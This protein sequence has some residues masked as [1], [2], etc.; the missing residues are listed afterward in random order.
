MDTKRLLG[1]AAACVT[2]TGCIHND[3]DGFAGAAELVE[4]PAG[5]TVGVPVAAM[6]STQG[7]GVATDQVTFTFNDEDGESFTIG[8]ADGTTY[9]FSIDQVV[10][11]RGRADSHRDFIYFKG[12]DAT[13]GVT[14]ASPVAREKDPNGEYVF[15]DFEP[16]AVLAGLNPVETDPEEED[17]GTIVYAVI[18]D[19]TD[20]LP[21]GTAEYHGDFLF[22]VFQDGGNLAEV[23]GHSQ[24]TADFDQAAVGVELGGEYFIDDLPYAVALTGSDLPVTGSRYDGDIGGT[25]EVPDFTGNDA[26]GVAGDLLGAFFGDAAE[27][28]AGVVSATSDGLA[29]Q[30]QAELPP[31]TVEVVGGY[32]AQDSSF[33]TQ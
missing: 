5:T 19:E 23:R 4:G 15:G 13:L 16:V 24:I 21:T 2:A 30:N 10:P 22:T 8:L 26:I 17:L 18:G 9:D 7:E 14:L 32:V 27:V 33:K 6:S 3:N 1:V 25:V 28:T 29:I 31:P 20:A 12:E 11:W